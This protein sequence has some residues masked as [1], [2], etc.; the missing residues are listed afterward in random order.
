MY[1]NYLLAAVTDVPFWSALRDASSGIFVVPRTRL[2]L[3]RGRFL[4]LLQYEHLTITSSTCEV[5]MRQYLTLFQVRGHVKM[6]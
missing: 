6:P 3:V 4:S 5:R 1:I 2:K